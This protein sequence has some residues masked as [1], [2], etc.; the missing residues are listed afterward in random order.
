MKHWKTITNF[1][2]V[3]DKGST[4]EV[5]GETVY[6]NGKEAREAQEFLKRAAGRR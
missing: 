2:K 1:D 4:F 5:N 6:W 3:L